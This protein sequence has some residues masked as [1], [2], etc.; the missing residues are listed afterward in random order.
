[1]NINLKLISTVL[2]VCGYYNINKKNTKYV[3]NNIMYEF[4]FKIFKN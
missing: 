3:I 2:F 1:M 4:E